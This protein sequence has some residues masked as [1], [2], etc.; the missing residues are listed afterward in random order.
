MQ[1]VLGET[2]MPNVSV[3][4]S[5]YKGFMTSPAVGH[6]MAAIALNEHSDHP[7]V[8]PLHPRRF[9]TGDLVPEPLT[10]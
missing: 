7:A 9:A 1:A 4:V 5:A 8:A 6:I 10:V 3:A 2:D